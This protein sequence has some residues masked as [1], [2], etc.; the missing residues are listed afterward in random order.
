MYRRIINKYFTNLNSPNTINEIG[1]TE[2]I[3][4][5]LAWALIGSTVLPCIG[6]VLAVIIARQ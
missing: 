1:I 6:G 2:S 3:S 4:W 5:R